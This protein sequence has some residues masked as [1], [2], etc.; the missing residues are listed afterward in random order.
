MSI[1]NPRYSEIIE[2]PEKHK[3]DNKSTDRQGDSMPQLFDH[4]DYVIKKI[5]NVKLKPRGGRQL[6]Q[7]PTIP[8]SQPAAGL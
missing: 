8:R 2:A 1:L 3:D 7:Q 4:I 5:L 6:H